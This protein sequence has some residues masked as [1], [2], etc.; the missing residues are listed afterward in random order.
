MQRCIGRKYTIIW[1]WQKHL[2]QPEMELF[3]DRSPKWVSAPPSPDKKVIRIL[4]LVDSYCNISLSFIELLVALYLSL[5]VVQLRF[6]DFFW[7]LLTHLVF[8]WG[9]FFCIK[10]LYYGCTYNQI[11]AG[12]TQET[13][14][15]I[16]CT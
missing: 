10:W 7:F 1:Y 14:G 3:Y 5:Y 16:Y 6:C 2:K 8:S 4:I 11:L 15:Y 9:F 12:T 13:T